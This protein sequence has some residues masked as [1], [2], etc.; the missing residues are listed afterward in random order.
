M[1]F[2][3]KF[4]TAFIPLFFAIDAVGILPVFLSMTSDVF[5]DK[6]RTIVNQAVITA[7]FISFAFMYLG[8][9]IFHFLGISIS[10]FK[11]AG[12][13]LL[14]VIS[15]YDLVTTRENRVRNT[16]GVDQTETIGIVPIG[17]P[18]IV[19]PAVL[20]TLLLLTGT[21]GYTATTTALVV[22]IFIVWLVFWYS[23]HIIKIIRRAGAIALGKVFA[24]LLAAI[25]IKMIRLGATEIWTSF[26]QTK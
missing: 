18:L 2:W 22:N 6:R 20:T 26:S 19:G 1:S 15:T 24:L 12:G 11:I 7:F 9:G 3:T 4:L 25:A 5:I 17:M 23:D 21:S 8:K 16:S 13:I 14:L 10:D